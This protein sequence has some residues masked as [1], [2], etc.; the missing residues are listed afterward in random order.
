MRVFIGIEIPEFIRAK[1][2]RVNEILK[3]DGLVSGNFVGKNELHLTLK[4]LG[5]EIDGA[6]LIKIKG[7]LSNVKWKPFNCKIKDY[8]FFPDENNIKILWAGVESKELILFT[9]EIEKLL[10]KEGFRPDESK[11]ELQVHLTLA[12]I[13][14]VR[15][16]IKFKEKLN[17]LKF[18]KLDFDVNE[19]CLFKSELTR[20]GPIYKKIDSFDLKI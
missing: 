13:S 1:L 18:G 16:K 12:R 2:T 15:D 17:E 14:N 19:I 6:D 5:D 3:R 9:K 4:F 20:A 8:G 11:K 7:I 10:S